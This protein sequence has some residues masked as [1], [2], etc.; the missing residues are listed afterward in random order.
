MHRSASGYLGPHVLCL[1]SSVWLAEIKCSTYSTVQYSTRP[2]W[3]FSVNKQDM[4]CVQREDRRD[5][6]RDTTECQLSKE[7]AN[8]GRQLSNG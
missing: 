8:K 3:M 7:P 5:S 1:E 2:G 4:R 6:G